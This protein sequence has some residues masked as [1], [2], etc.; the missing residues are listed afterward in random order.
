MV[1]SAAHLVNHV[2]PEAPV[3]LWPW[4]IR[5]ILEHVRCRELLPETV[6]RGPPGELLESSRRV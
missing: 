3:R 1:E 4:L 2:F 6:A 5:K